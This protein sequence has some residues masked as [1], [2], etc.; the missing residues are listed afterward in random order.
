MQNMFERAVAAFP[1]THEL[2][3]QYTKYLERHLKIPAVINQVY[4]RALR[5][6]PW[7]G[8]LWARG[9]RAL[10][11]GGGS[12]QQHEE[13]YNK[14]LQAG[15]QVRAVLLACWRSACLLVRS[16]IGRFVSRFVS[17]LTR[18]LVVYQSVDEVLNTRDLHIGLSFCVNDPESQTLRWI[19][20]LL[21]GSG[22][23]P[24]SHPGSC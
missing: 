6:C 14:A 15:M 17:D 1:V 3:Q 5:N 13:M 16:F 2:W 23:L 8:P 12:L 4:G 7:M 19:V 18:V 9:L 20:I 21:T 22:G 11:R 10:Q 24:R